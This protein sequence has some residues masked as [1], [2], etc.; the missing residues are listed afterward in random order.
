MN[1]L[2]S[3]SVLAI[4]LREAAASAHVGSAGAV[5]A[6]VGPWNRRARPPED[7]RW[8]WLMLGVV[9]ATGGCGRQPT[10]YER[11]LAALKQKDYAQAIAHF[12][13]ALQ[14]H[15]Q[16][17]VVWTVRGLAY[18]EQRQFAAAIA[19]YT[20]ALEIDPSKPEVWVRRAEAHRHQREP[21]LAINDCTAALQLDPTCVAAY[22]SRGVAYHEQNLLREAIADYTQAIARGPSETSAYFYRGAA[23]NEVGDYEAALADFDEVLRREPANAGA[24]NNRARTHGKKGNYALAVADYEQAIEHDPQLAYAYAGLAWLWATCPDPKLR[25]GQR[26][27]AYARQACQLQGWQ[28]VYCLDVLAAAYAE[29]GDYL[30]AVA[31]QRKALA[32]EKGFPP[33][34]LE[35]ARL[36]LKLYEAGQPYR[37]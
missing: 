21:Q 1:A 37:E 23:Y 19:S 4:D 24:Y 12:D 5:S 35:R 8:G 30:E 20:K 26:A 31:W 2:H 22:V 16:D 6:P 14:A 17:A 10:A 29:A 33:H 7:K 11:G 9:L 27:V 36:R 13:E 32:L 18:F 15:P 25:D 28:D 3:G 34:E